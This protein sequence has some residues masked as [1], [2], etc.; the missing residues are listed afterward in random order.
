MHSHQFGAGQA[1]NGHR[2][3]SFLVRRNRMLVLTS[4]SVER[5]GKS[6]FDGPQKFSVAA[7]VRTISSAQWSQNRFAFSSLES[8]V[9]ADLS[10]CGKAW[11]KYI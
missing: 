2:T 3:G 4:P 9:C 5:R 10:K 11:Q 8:R 1:R 6:L 7:S